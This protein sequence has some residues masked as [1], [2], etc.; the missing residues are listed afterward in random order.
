VADGRLRQHFWRVAD[1]L[2]YLVTLV[3]LRMLDAICGPPPGDPGLI[4]SERGSG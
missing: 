4:S 2:D 1:K 3:R